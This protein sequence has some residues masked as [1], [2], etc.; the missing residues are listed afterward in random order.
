MKLIVGLG[1]PGKEYAKT[2]H[3]A[4]FRVLD[5]LAGK[6]GV[7]FDRSKFKGEY[8]DAL[9]PEGW[10]G[11]GG[12]QDEPDD[13]KLLLV[14][15]QTY[16]N[17]SGETVQGFSGYYKIAVKDILVV[18]DEV[19]LPLGVLRMRRGG[20]AGGHNGLKDIALR[21]G[22]QEF[23]RLRLGVGGR[24]ALA[25]RKPGNLADHVLGRFSAEEEDV[26][27]KRIPEAVEA[28][29]CW[30]GRGVEAAMNKHNAGEKSS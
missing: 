23:A 25:E 16:M 18:V 1:N 6:L 29:L 12:S 5:L 26:L 10:R 28:C 14:K 15:P 20:S 19:A 30:A 9:L 4:G 8:C 7:G 27:R 17:L 21:L 11:K 2:R 22:S 13:G 24:D 3:N